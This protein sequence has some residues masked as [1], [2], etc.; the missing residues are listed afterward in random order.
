MS[1]KIK[2]C[3]RKLRTLSENY[4]REA[5][6]NKLIDIY[7]KILDELNSELDNLWDEY[8]EMV[9]YI[10]NNNEDANISY[11][12]L[13]LPNGN[14]LNV[15]ILEIGDEIVVAYDGL[16]GKAK[17]HEHDDFDFETGYNIAAT[18]LMMKVLQ[19]EYEF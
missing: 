7:T 3:H 11:D 9:S 10:Y 14:V 13:E 17:K 15:I 1:Q 6:I 5:D 18:R 16:V 2:R 19:R 8:G 12:L 4:E